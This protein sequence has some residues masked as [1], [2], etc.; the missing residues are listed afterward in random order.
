MCFL[1]KL[2]YFLKKLFFSEIPNIASSS[3]KPINKNRTDFKLLLIAINNSGF[4]Y[5]I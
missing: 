4:R 3:E 1:V 2:K 5:K